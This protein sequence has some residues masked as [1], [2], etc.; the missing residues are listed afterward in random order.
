MCVC[1]FFYSVISIN[2]LLLLENDNEYMMH[3]AQTVLN[4][5]WTGKIVNL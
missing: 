1:D 2:E 5:C 3:M 4:V